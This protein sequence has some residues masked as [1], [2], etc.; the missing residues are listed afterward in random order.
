MALDLSREQYSE[1]LSDLRLGTFPRQAGTPGRVTLGGWNSFFR[2]F[3]GN[4]G[5]AVPMFISHNAYETPALGGPIDVNRFVFSATFGDMDT[6]DGSGLRPGEVESEVV[7][8][9][10]WVESEG[11]AHAW[12][13]SGSYIDGQ[14][15]GFHLR[16]GWKSEPRHR[17]YLTRWESAFW[18]GLKHQLGLRSVNIVCAEPA[19][20]E[21]LPYTPYVHHKDP[22]SKEWKKEANYCVPVPH[23]WIREGRFDKVRDL[24]FSPY[25]V[26]PVWVP[27]KEP[28]LE[29]YVRTKG[30]E[31]FSH[32]AEAFHPA[33]TGEEYAATG[34]AIDLAK[35]LIP[36]K[37]C[38]RTLPYGANPR[39]EVRR[40][41]IIDILATDPD[42]WTEPE[43]QAFVD[44]VAEESKWE[45]RG[46]TSRRRYQVAYHWKR[47]YKP[48]SCNELREKGVCVANAITDCSLFP[49]AFPEEFAE[50]R[51]NHPEGGK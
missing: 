8:V 40:A 33:P 28:T 48:K 7:R 37:L 10:E 11:L 50:Y 41:W 3:E 14:P 23:D 43:I 16:I 42:G 18:R 20:F 47:K 22:L 34:N 4:Y 6:G 51:K 49:K 26:G 9:E 24:S 32:E 17:V 45:D 38:L 36:E 5:R 46:N 39:H 29:T 19:R 27:G 31:V 30:W 12:K 25:D 44:G 13:F 15:A 21:R 2:W 1:V 35:L